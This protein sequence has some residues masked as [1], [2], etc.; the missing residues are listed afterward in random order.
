MKT[1]EPLLLQLL[2]L[3]L[4]PRC[5]LA[6]ANKFRNAPPGWKS[7]ILP[8]SCNY[9]HDCD[10]VDFPPA[11]CPVT[12]ATPDGKECEKSV[13][14]ATG[15]MTVCVCIKYFIAFNS[16]EFVGAK[17]QLNE[18]TNAEETKTAQQPVA[19]QPHP[20]EDTKKVS[21]KPPTSSCRRC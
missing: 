3:T 12:A 4:L 17:E 9:Y 20:R 11:V 1:T 2:L 6:F 21:T 5:V 15:R 14:A 7:T 13:L 19:A 10:H 18:T 8:G 16:W